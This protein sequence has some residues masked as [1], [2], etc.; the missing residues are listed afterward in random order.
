[1][2]AFC[3]LLLNLL[4]PSF[5]GRVALFLL[6][7]ATM[8]PPPEANLGERISQFA[9]STALLTVSLLILKDPFSEKSK[10]MEDLRSKFVASH[11][12]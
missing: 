5:K 2:V 1:V 10:V 6:T 3:Y 11:A 7:Y 4:V 12:L 8:Q 9:I